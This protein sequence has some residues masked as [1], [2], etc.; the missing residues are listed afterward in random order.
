MKKKL[1]KLKGK[2]QKIK[3]M[4]YN[5]VRCYS[6]KIDFH[7]ASFARHLKSNK[8]LRNMKQKFEKIP[9]KTPIKRIEKK[10]NIS[11]T[12]VENLNHFTDRIL[13]VAYDIL[14]DNHQS[15]H[16]NSILPIVSNVNK[17][18]VENSHINKILEEMARIHAKLTNQRKIK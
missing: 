17:I 4:K 2:S 6:C 3:N 7:R 18:G 1:K 9:R 5:R 11:G 14:L 8:Q 10:I 16:A 15:S 13:N 12:K